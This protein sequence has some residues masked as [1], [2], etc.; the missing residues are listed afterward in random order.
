[1]AFGDRLIAAGGVITGLGGVVG[2]GYF[3][4][5][6]QGRVTFWDWP[7]V[8]SVVVVVVGLVGVA[9]GLLRPH[10]ELGRQGQ[11]GGDGSVNVQAG[12]DIN[13]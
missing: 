6:L 7:G 13:L 9:I 8:A 5:A 4:Y 11:S 1:M 3:V 12:R 10:R 2:A